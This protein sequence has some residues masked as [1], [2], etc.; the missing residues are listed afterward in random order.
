M[1]FILFDQESVYKD[2]RGQ[3]KRGDPFQQSENNILR[4]IV[5]FFLAIR[6]VTMNI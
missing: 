5:F 3:L 4:T 2:I 1:S 6:C